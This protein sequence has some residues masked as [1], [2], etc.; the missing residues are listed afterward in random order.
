MRAQI[1][2]ECDDKVVKTDINLEC[3]HTFTHIQKMMEER[4]LE[5]CDFLVVLLN[6]L[7]L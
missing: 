3:S 4:E 6:I 5:L 7:L 2:C 1:G